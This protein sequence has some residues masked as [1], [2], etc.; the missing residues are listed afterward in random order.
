MNRR[1]R[2]PATSRVLQALLKSAHKNMEKNADPGNEALVL[3][4]ALEEHGYVAIS[5][6]LKK[7]ALDIHTFRELIPRPRER[8]PSQAGR[9]P[10]L[11]GDQWEVEML[12]AKTTRARR[13]A[14][15][16]SLGG[17]RVREGPPKLVS[18]ASSRRVLQE[19]GRHQRT[20]SY[21]EKA[22]FSILQI[23]DQASKIGWW[24]RLTR[25]SPRGMAWPVI[26]IR[27]EDDK[28][29]QALVEPLLGTDKGKQVVI[30]S[31]FFLPFD[32]RKGPASVY[33]LAPGARAYLP[34]HAQGTR[35]TSSLQYLREGPRGPR[36]RR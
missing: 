18:S 25:G 20:W 22:I 28:G 16:L 30:P 34:P 4:D 8:F 9:N 1:R 27:W 36:R 26:F 24:I 17:T 35:M 5:N 29:R 2:D 33:T 23:I 31:E 13:L 7:L 10:Y 19:I 32:P 14:L 3:A 6:A 11:F 12:P 21:L 15:S